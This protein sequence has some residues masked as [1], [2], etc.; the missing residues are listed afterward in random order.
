MAYPPVVE[1][2][3]QALRSFAPGKEERDSVQVVTF[4][5]GRR[6]VSA[7][8]EPQ[9]EVRVSGDTGGAVADPHRCLVQLLQG[10]TV[11]SEARGIAAAAVGRMAKALYE[12]L[13]EQGLKITPDEVIAAYDEDVRAHRRPDLDT[14]LGVA[15]DD[16]GEVWLEVVDHAY[17]LGYDIEGHE[18]SGRRMLWQAYQEYQERLRAEL[19]LDPAVA[20]R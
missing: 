2:V 14:L 10:D 11:V 8:Y 7:F 18:G 9:V 4:D 17:R 20:E 3:V 13:Q 5:Q 12:C 15:Q 6:A 1:T 16:H 19:G